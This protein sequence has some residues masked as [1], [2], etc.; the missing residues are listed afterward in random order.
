MKISYSQISKIDDFIKKLVDDIEK[1]AKSTNSNNIYKAFGR[2]NIRNLLEFALETI[3]FYDYNTFLIK[4]NNLKKCPNPAIKKN[5]NNYKITLFQKLLSFLE[6][7]P[8]LN[9]IEIKLKFKITTAFYYTTFNSRRNKY[10]SFKPY[11]RR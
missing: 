8:D 5:L 2:F 4:F 7:E 9:D 1:Q 3:N 11:R 10:K 6:H